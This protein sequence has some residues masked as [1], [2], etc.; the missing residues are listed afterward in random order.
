MN[1]NKT[2]AWA[3]SVLVFIV[4]AISFA[5]SYHALQ[6]VAA[7]NGLTGWLSYIWP[8]LVDFS[9]VV[10]SLCVVSAHLYSESTW[11]QWCLVSISTSLTVFYNALYAYPEMLIPLAQRLLIIDLPPVMLFC[12]FE[13]LMSQLKNSVARQGIMTTIQALNTISTQRQEQLFLL[14]STIGTLSNRLSDIQQQIETL[15]MPADSVTQRRDKLVTIISEYRSLNDGKLPTQGYL[16]DQTGVTTQTI[17][18][19]LVAING[20]GK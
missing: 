16:A 17:R 4:A 10:F 8:L 1:L 2:I 6:G 18:G 3:T 13:L 20:V 15:T 9:L 5:L 12:S 7:A 19:D 14:D 11:K